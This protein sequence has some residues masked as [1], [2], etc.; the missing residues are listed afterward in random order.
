MK[1]LNVAAYGQG[2]MYKDLAKYRQAIRTAGWD[3]I[4]L[5]MLH[6]H[7]EDDKKR[8]QS[9]YFGNIPILQN[10]T[11]IGD[12]KWP[13]QLKDL[14]KGEGTSLYHLLAGIGGGGVGDFANIMQIYQNNNNS[15]DGTVLQT[16]F[17][18]FHAKFPMIT[19]LDMDVEDAYD[20]PSF[21]AFCQMLIQIGFGITFCP[22]TCMD[23]WTGSLKQLNQ[24]N[25]GA[26]KWW[27]LQCYD[28]GTG[29]D[30]QQWADA[31]S[32]AIPGFNTTG[33]ILPG[34][35]SRNLAKQDK[36]DPST[37]YWQGDCPPA[38]R[39]L[40]RSFK[41]EPCVG[42]GFIWTIDQILGYVDAQKEKPDPHPC[43]NVGMKDYIAAI[44]GVLG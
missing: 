42:G 1:T 29:N 23:F 30:P 2:I 24:S 8:T 20:I 18:T 9:I 41:D 34:D 31:I 37:W 14:L 28:G 13:S 10:G 17:Q 43:G 33:F 15:F 39:Q 12:S 38:V 3:S 22:Y 4:I 6:P 26:V 40:M 21:V 36:N 11:Y 35:W 25:P 19:M 27:N 7:P 5:G 16:N 44:T 32:K